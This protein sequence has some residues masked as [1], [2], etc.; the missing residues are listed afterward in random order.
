MSLF[1]HTPHPHQPQN[2]N[3]VHAQERAEGNGWQRLNERIAVLLTTI[4]GT[5]ECAYVFA[6]IAIMGLLGLLGYLNATVYL[7][8]GWTSQQLI[9][10]VLLSVIMVGQNVQARKQELLAEEQ[11]N[12]T[13]KTYSDIEQIMAHLSAQDDEILKQTELLTQLLDKDKKHA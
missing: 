1:D 7:L 12:T 6:A 9:Q 2:I 5:M 11:F 8:A 3:V 10:L 13:M 4:V